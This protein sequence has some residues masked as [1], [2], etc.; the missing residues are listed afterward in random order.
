MKCKDCKWWLR[1]DK[2][3]EG[4]TRDL[5]EY[6]AAKEK[7][8]VAGFCVRFPPMRTIG[9]SMRAGWVVTRP[10]DYCGEFLRRSKNMLSL[11]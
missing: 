9:C 4:K 7:P 3:A 11:L 5:Y 8:F 1:A 2:G 6:T 10:D